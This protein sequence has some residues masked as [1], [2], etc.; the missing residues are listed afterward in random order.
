M[1]KIHALDSLLWERGCASAP[2][3]CVSPTGAGN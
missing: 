2:V 3:D 1:G